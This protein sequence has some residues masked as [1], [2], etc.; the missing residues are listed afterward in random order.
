[1]SILS[2]YLKKKFNVNEFSEL[3]E[4]EKETYR[5]WDDILSGKKITDEDVKNFL[6]S[7]LEEV[8]IKLVNPNLT[9]R[10]DIFL[11]MKM[12]F[13]RKINMFLLTPEIERKTL[14]EQIKKLM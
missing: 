5:E 12:E 11:K 4:E 14:E 2:T 3:S 9:P 13:I 10:E 6:G 7:E 8:Q 1:M